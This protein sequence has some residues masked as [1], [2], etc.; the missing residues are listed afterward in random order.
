M[1]YYYKNTINNCFFLSTE[2]I[3]DENIISLSQDEWE[4]EIEALAAEEVIE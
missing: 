3:N 4:S 2:E 1:Q